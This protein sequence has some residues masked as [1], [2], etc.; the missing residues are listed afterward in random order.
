MAY[1]INLMTLPLARGALVRYFDYYRSNDTGR[2]REG[3]SSRKL[4][5]EIGTGGTPGL[6]CERELAKIFDF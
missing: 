1:A 3:T 6:P 5:C 2:V 4:S